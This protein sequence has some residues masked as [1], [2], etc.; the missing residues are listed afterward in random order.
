MTTPKT[1]QEAFNLIK[2]LLDYK[3]SCAVNGWS[4]HAQGLTMAGPPWRVTVEIKSSKAG[5]GTAIWMITN[6]ISPANA[7]AKKISAGC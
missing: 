3:T 4:A 2:P 5:A 6:K 1:S 7:L